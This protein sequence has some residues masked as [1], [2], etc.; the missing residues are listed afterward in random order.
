MNCRKGDGLGKTEEGI[1]VPVALT[2]KETRAGLGL[3][4]KSKK[5]LRKLE[6]ATAQRKE[7]VAVLE[8]TFRDRLKSKFVEKKVFGQWRQSKEICVQMDKEKGYTDSVY[9]KDFEEEERKKQEEGDDYVR[10]VVQVEDA[11]ENLQNALQYL[12]DK[13]CYCFF[14]GTSYSDEADLLSGCP[15]LT[16]EDHET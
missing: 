8:N 13:H 4:S 12:R 6:E 15:G 3:E 10:P 16:E 11:Y 7:H 5:R 9:V 2:I 1:K 14:C